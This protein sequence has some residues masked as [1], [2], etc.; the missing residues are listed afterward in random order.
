MHFRQSVPVLLISLL[1]ACA[2]QQTFTVRVMKPA[3]VDLGRYRLVAIERLDGEGAIALSQELTKALQGAQNPLTGKMDFEVLDRG[4][5]DRLLEDLRRRRTG[6]SDKE[7][8]EL[9]ERWKNADVVIRGQVRAHKVSDEVIGQEWID[10]TTGQRHMQF[11]RTCRA[12]VAVALEIVTGD[13]EH[14]VDEAH[15][16][17]CVTRT[18]IA[19]D[20]E[21]PKIDHAP[22]LAS[23]RQRVVQGYLDRMLPHEERVGVCLQIDGD[24]PELQA[25][26]GYA[27]TGDWEEAA[28]SY[29]AAVARAQGGLAAARWKAL[30]NLGIAQLYTNHFEPARKSLKAAYSLEQQQVILGALQS[31]TQRER[32]WQALQQQSRAGAGPTR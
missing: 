24:L 16:D 31:V 6:A 22:L 21:P 2:S 13:K 19:L 4:E 7:T 1:A 9:L 12:R 18:A 25:G 15:F 27:M 5:V 32:E 8:M 30:Y 23:A 3:P 20:V 28:R 29:E 26:N 10:R 11:V 17:E 14:P